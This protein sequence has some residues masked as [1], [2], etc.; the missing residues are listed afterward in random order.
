L[1]LRDTIT[2]FNKE[3]GQERACLN[4]LSAPIIPISMFFPEICPSNLQTQT[5]L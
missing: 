3:K 1:K 5:I 2:K 4:C